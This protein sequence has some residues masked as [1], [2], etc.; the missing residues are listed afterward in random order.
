MTDKFMIYG[1][2]G[3]TGR[4]TARTAVQQGLRPI[5]AGRNPAKVAALAQELGLEGR[6]IA[7][8]D[9]AG[10][11][12][13]L[14][15]VA[16]VLHCAGPFS[17]TYPPMAAACLRTGTHYLDITGEI[18]EHEALAGRDA[19]ARAAG[20]MMLPSA[21]YDVVPSDCLAAHLKRRL[22]SATHLALAFSSAGG[23]SRHGHHRHG[24]GESRGWCAGTG[25]ITPVPAGWKSRTVDFGHPRPGRLRDDPWGATACRSTGIPNTFET[26]VAVPK[27]R[28]VGA[29]VRGCWGSRWAHRQAGGCCAAWWG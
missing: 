24:D 8:D 2:T 21:G 1:A 15:E 19:E 25:T 18:A 12:A 29:Q 26:Y 23:S 28:A 4:L 16:V 13:A 10:L 14:R 22:P 3:Y 7:L 17:Q 27:M 9:S 5:L 6:A 11:D 20:V